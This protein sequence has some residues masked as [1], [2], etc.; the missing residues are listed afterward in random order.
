MR[1]NKNHDFEQPAIYST[2]RAEEKQKKKYVETCPIAYQNCV[3]CF[4]GVTS[5]YKRNNI[6]RKNRLRKTV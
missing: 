5:F 2:K 6:E 1:E 3:D 4:R